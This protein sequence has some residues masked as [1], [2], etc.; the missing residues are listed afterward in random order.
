MEPRGLVV[1]LDFGLAE[2]FGQLVHTL[3]HDIKWKPTAAPEEDIMHQYDETAPR[4]LVHKCVSRAE[5]G[6]NLPDTRFGTNWP[7]GDLLLPKE[8]EAAVIV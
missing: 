5:R 8:F 3:G 4:E 1:P 7:I 2:Q 6:S